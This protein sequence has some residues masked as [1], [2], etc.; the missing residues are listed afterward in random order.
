MY[1]S[2]DMFLLIFAFSS[3][4]QNVPAELF[5]TSFRHKSQSA[6]V[7]GFSSKTAKET[8]ATFLLLILLSLYTPEIPADQDSESFFQF[9]VLFLRLQILQTQS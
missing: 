5:D 6:H 1:R 2:N 9:E 4:F 3:S 7:K 8:D